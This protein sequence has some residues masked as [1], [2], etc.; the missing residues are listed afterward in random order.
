MGEMAFQPDAIGNAQ[1]RTQNRLDYETT[2]FLGK[3]F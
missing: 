2:N 1:N 3:Y